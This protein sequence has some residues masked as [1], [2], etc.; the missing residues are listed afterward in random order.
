MYGISSIQTKKE[1]E[2][3]L[4]YSFSTYEIASGSI[5]IQY[6]EEV[7]EFVSLTQ[8]DFLNDKLVDINSSLNG[9]VYISFLGTEYANSTNIFN[10]KF[11]TIKNE[12]I[13][14]QI[15]AVVSDLYDL[16]L[17]NIT[18]W[19]VCSS[20]RPSDIDEEYLFG[21]ES[22]CPNCRHMVA[23]YN[24]YYCPNCGQAIDWSDYND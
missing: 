11:K 21:K 17:D 12:T 13:T 4:T 24:G 20:R 6:D 3:E 5:E 23:P 19:Y 9:S 15:K 22:V 10:I 16:D 7:F 18:W 2:F 8:N 1:E 14:S